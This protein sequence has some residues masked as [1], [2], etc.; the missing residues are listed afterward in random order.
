MTEFEA[1]I[2]CCIRSGFRTNKSIAHALARQFKGSVGFRIYDNG[3]NESLIK[4]GY[5]KR[6]PTK[7]ATLQLTRAGEAMIKN[8]ALEVSGKQVVFMRFEY[9]PKEHIPKAYKPGRAR[10]APKPLR[11]DICTRETHNQTQFCSNLG[12][13]LWVCPTC[14]EGWRL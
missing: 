7:S 2:L 5:I 12:P 8:C 3:K 10:Y 14:Y 6:Q 1:A 4:R 11:C 13:A 9:I